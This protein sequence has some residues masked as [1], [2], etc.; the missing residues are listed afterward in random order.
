MPQVQMQDPSS[1][2]FASV[3][4]ATAELRANVF[5]EAQRRGY[6][7]DIPAFE[8]YEEWCAGRQF[9]ALPVKI[10]NMVLY[11]L[12]L[13]AGGVPKHLVTNAVSSIERVHMMTNQ[14][15]RHLTRQALKPYYRALAF[16]KGR[17]VTSD[18]TEKERQA[19]QKAIE[20]FPDGVVP[21]RWN[22][23]G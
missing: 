16:A 13:S 8:Q 15:P 10:E 17:L 11:L 22:D 6:A 5:A 21:M 2:E 1:E 20:M 23:I 14:P 4:S 3:I 12:C 19:P 18:L 9:D 7:G